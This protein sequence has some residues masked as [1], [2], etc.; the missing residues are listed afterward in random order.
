M[1][2]SQAEALWSSLRESFVNAEKVLIQI[3]EAKAWEPLGYDTFGQAWADRMAGVRLA[4]ALTANVVYALL[5]EGM[6][7]QKIVALAGV[8]PTVVYLLA[9]QKNNVVPVEMAKLQDTVVRA[10]TRV[11][12]SAPAFLHLELNHGELASLKALCAAK[13]VDLNSEALKAVRVHFSR[14]ERSRSK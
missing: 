10:H 12:P 3:I 9:R 13:G 5:D 8:G 4:G 1:K 7:A 11:K 6:K 2:Q 14:L